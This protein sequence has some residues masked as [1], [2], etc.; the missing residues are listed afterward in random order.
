MKRTFI[1]AIEHRRTIY[2][3]DNQQ[4]VS[5]DRIEQIVLKALADIPSAFNSRTTRLVLLSGE[6]HTK[7]WS[8]VKETLRKIVPAE[9]FGATEQKIDTSFAAGYATVLFYEDQS[10][11][12]SLQEQFPT[13]A[14]RFPGWSEHTSA[15]HQF[16]IWT[17]VEDEGLGAS[18]QHY[19]P[20]IDR[21]VAD[22]FGISTHWKLVAQM[23]L[24]RPIAQ[25]APKPEWNP[26]E[27]YV[28]L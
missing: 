25:P 7:F 9:G 1:E 11:V 19:N 6:N 3:I 21:E 20:I 15:M 8:I 4:I 13:Y 12:K 26:A 27:H 24:G 22:T 18:L 5:R 23:P 17:M 10:V 16:A 14:D 2:N 28:S